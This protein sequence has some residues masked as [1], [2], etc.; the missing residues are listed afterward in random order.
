MAGT[1]LSHCVPATLRR[2]FRRAKKPNAS[3]RAAA[4]GE[5]IRFTSNILPK[6]AR[7]TKSLDASCS[8]PV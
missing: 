8:P 7:R 2:C 3:D 1:G 4:S 5:R 6:W